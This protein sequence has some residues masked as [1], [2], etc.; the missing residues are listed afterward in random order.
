MSST[1]WTVIEQCCEPFRAD[2]AFVEYFCCRLP[3]GFILQEHANPHFTCRSW[4]RVARAFVI[5]EASTCSL[6]SST[7][8]EPILYPSPT[9]AFHL[10]FCEISN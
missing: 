6:P 5:T 1:C 8:P 2:T 7:S 4:S 10:S 9:I 3:A